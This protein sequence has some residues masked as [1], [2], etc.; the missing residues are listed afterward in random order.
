[1]D[2]FA[3]ACQSELV[4]DGDR[5]GTAGSSRGDLIR[6]GQDGVWTPS[7]MIS[8]AIQASLMIEFLGA[9]EDTGLEVLG[10]LSSATAGAVPD[11]REGSSLLVSPC[12][13]LSSER[14]LPR[15]R[16]VLERARERSWICGMFAGL[17]EIDPSYSVAAA[18]PP[19]RR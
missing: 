19:G 1:M 7:E 16:D 11:E 8:V 18:S 5:T 14:D 4:W 13:V 3:R 10:Y 17:L 12:I 9:A 6:V 15:A 2:P